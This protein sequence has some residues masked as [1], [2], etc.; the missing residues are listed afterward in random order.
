[1]SAF[2]KVRDV[3]K[4]DGHDRPAR[5]FPPVEFEVRDGTD[6]AHLFGAREQSEKRWRHASLPGIECERRRQHRKHADQVI[7]NLG[8]D[9]FARAPDRRTETEPAVEGRRRRRCGQRPLQQDFR[10]VDRAARRQQGG[11]RNPSWSPTMPW[12]LAS[13]TRPPRRCF[14]GEPPCHFTS[15]RRDDSQRTP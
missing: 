15:R 5:A 8:I 4:A 7:G 11:A 10:R 12:S 6:E 13:H 14:T 2:G 9:A 3:S 1:M